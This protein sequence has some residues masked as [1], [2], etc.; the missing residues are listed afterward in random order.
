MVHKL[1][2]ILQTI[3][4]LK[5]HDHLIL[6]LQICLLHSVY[7]RSDLLCSSI[8]AVRSRL[9]GL[10]IRYTDPNNPT[11]QHNLSYINNIKKYVH[12]NST[13]NENILVIVHNISATN[14]LNV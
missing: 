3:H 9:I 4:C 13:I 12:N 10:R 8:V 1:I 14:I 5:R 6:R 11:E 7:Y 2:R